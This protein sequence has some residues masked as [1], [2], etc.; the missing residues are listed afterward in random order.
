[1][2]KYYFVLALLIVAISCKKDVPQEPEPTTT[3][4]T[5]TTPPADFSAVVQAGGSFPAPV[6]SSNV[7]T[8]VDS[9]IDND[10]LYACV[11]ET[12]DIVQGLQEFPLFNPNSS[13]IYPGNLLQG[14]SLLNATPDVIVVNRAGGTFSI[15][16]L[17]GGNN[18][19]ETVSEVTKS[20][21]I[22]ALN[23][24]I[25][26]APSDVPANIS[27]FME[28]VHSERELALKIGVDYTQAF[29]A[30][31]TE[32]GFSSGYEY[33]RIF[34]K[35]SQAYYTM[36]FDLPASYS[37]LF[38][39][40]VTPADLSPY[41]GPGNPAAYISDVTYGR[42]FYLLIESTAS[43]T[44][45]KASLNSSFSGV[46]NSGEANIDGS[47]LSSLENL[48]IKLY[49]LGGDAQTTF[50]TIGNNNISQLVST[51]GNA[52]EITTGVPLSYVCRAVHNNQ[53][54]SVNLATQYDI[55]NCTPL[56]PATG[57]YVTLPAP[58][59]YLMADDANTN[60]NGIISYDNNANPD[61]GTYSVG[62]TYGTNIGGQVVESWPDDGGIIIAS[63][64][65]PNNRP[66]W[67]PDA[68]NGYAAIEFCYFYGDGSG[69]STFY[70]QEVT[71]ELDLP[72][73]QFINTDYTL[74]MVVSSPTKLNV[75]G[76]YITN[77]T[78]EPI[79]AGTFMQGTDNTALNQQ[80]VGFNSNNNL[81]FGHNTNDLNVPLSRSPEFR[82]IT[83]RFSK[84]E[85]MTAWINSNTT[86]LAD[87]NTLTNPL[88]SNSGLK[89]NAKSLTD[90]AASCRSQ[91]VEIR[92]YNVAVTDSDRQLIISS[93]MTKYGL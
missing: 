77:F 60:V 3:T 33:N 79:N 53:I 91:V 92:A 82:L 41:I 19:S 14:A 8:S 67:I 43:E 86:A 84:I 89:L 40:T 12:Y 13:V 36:S 81:V 38:A 62:N 93:I 54:V 6:N 76:S 34:V 66:V 87:D 78:S 20:K 2:K 71:T 63:T 24:I 37:D 48:N 68:L 83:L 9:M 31:E 1:M 47:Y 52:G 32:L 72:G 44:E 80:T 58:M 69:S 25:D 61:L 57:T 28:E 73:T 70:D 29:F 27:F 75:E 42:I 49:A 55:T 85:G 15:D 23:D 35:L 56:G 7:T 5:T 74:F 88:L 64:S 51:L 4:T 26:N 22:Q 17:S 65:D 45:I 59:L 11:T 39:P 46:A 21:V 30:I 10:T 50:N 16:I 90:P 18:V